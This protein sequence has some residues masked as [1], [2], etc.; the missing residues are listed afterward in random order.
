MP[1]YITQTEYLCRIAMLV[2]WPI[3]YGNTMAVA[4]TKIDIDKQNKKYYDKR[5][6]KKYG[7]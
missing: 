2:R 7:P 5:Q 3:Q 1:E 6:E 4:K